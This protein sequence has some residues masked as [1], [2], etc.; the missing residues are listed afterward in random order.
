[1][2][3]DILFGAEHSIS[4]YSLILDPL[5]EVSLDSSL[6][7]DTNRSFSGTDREVHSNISRSWFN[8]VSISRIIVME[9][10]LRHKPCL[11]RYS[12][13][14]HG[15]GLKSNQKTVGN[16]MMPMSL[17]HKWACFPGQSLL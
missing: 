7:S 6:L 3:I 12:W 1:M 8:I 13:P 14:I 5:G 11:E 15:V 10:P 9:P 16:S 4:S 17:L 2:N